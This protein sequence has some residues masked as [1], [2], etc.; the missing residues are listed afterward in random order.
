MRVL[1][2]VHLGVEGGVSEQM[3]KNGGKAKEAT[4]EDNGM[5]D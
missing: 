1:D 5:L 3:R 2:I 4:K